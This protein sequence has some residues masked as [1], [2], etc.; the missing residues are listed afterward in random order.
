M[1]EPLNDFQISLKEIEFLS[2]KVNQ[3]LELIFVING[4]IT[5]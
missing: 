4:E 3:G 2:P 1:D 5:D